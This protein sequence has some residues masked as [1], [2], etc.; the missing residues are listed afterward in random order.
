MDTNGSG[1]SSRGV[2]W[3]LMV[4]VGGQVRAEKR[5]YDRNEAART[6]TVVKP[7]SSSE[8][9]RS[10]FLEISRTKFPNFLKF[11]LLLFSLSDEKPLGSLSCLV[12][13]FSPDLPVQAT[14]PI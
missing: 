5:S 6:L 8:S 4:R 3:P 2:I 12:N 11:L 14:D 10:D 7:D 13:S 1:K 9:G